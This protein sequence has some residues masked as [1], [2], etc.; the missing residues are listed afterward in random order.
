MVPE[1][2]AQYRNSSWHSFWLEL[3]PAYDAFEQHRRPP[4]ISVRSGKYAV[5]VK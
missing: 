3:K 1:K 4:Q 5:I 2:M